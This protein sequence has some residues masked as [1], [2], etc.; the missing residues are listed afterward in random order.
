MAKICLVGHDM[1]PS[2][3]FKLL[4]QEL[5]SAGHT[6]ELRVGC[7]KPISLTDEDL[8]DSILSSRLVIIGMSSSP[9]FAET[10]VKA[11][12]IAQEAGIPFGFYGDTYNCW[13]R[14]RKGAWFESFV[15]DAA[16]YF[17][18]NQDDVS[19]AA[20]LFSNAKCF[21]TGNPL[22]EKMA[23]PEVTRNDVRQKLGIA[24]DEKLLLVSGTKISAGNMAM[25]SAVIEAAA[26]LHRVSKL[27]LQVVFC[28]HPGDTL[29]RAVDSASGN[30]LMPYEEH[31][32]LSPIP[33]RVVRRDEMLSSHVLAGSDLLVEFT[34]SMGLEAAYQRIPTITMLYEP[35]L[36]S[37]EAEMGSRWMEAVANNITWGIRGNEMSSELPTAIR[38]LLQPDDYNRRR[39]ITAQCKHYP[40]PEVAGR[41][42]AKMVQAILQ[43][44]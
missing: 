30:P 41:A 8:R 31:L 9:L 39:L 20:T 44:L 18:L 12:K 33:A 27:T 38:T 32:Q 34:G 26:Y 3:C 25:C 24:D 21:A 15:S 36:K 1:A 40:I 19:S 10:E 11:G 14:A 17:G 29:L 43:M 22:R 16:F 4:A 6:P 35:L 37:F 42:V 5:L 7:G 13:Q 2:Q 28:P 23:F